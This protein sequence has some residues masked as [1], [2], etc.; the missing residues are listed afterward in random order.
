MQALTGSWPVRRFGHSGPVWGRM[1]C[2][3]TVQQQ[4][5][6][7]LRVLEEWWRPL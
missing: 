1:R 3:P 5:N 6:V 2:N 7:D 4:C